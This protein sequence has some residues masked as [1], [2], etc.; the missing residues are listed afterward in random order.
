MEK[1]KTIEI[2]NTLITIN[3]DRIKG[4]ET[5][6]KE[7]QEQ[8]LKNL[9]VQ[10]TA[11]SQKCKEELITEVKKLG[12]D[13]SEGK[14]ISG[15]FLCLWMDL[16]KAALL[17]TDRKVILKSCEYVEEITVDTYF[18]ALRNNMKDITAEQQIMINGQHILI[19]DDYNNIKS[20]RDALA[21]A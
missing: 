10:F 17:C 6:S 5:A 19:K 13:L 9:F 2:L 11:T 7:T 21:Y 4:Y 1:E 3:N 14:I 16:I 18:K 20:M 15:K 8:D 12:G